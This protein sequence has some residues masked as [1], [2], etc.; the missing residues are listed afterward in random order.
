MKAFAEKYQKS[1]AQICLRW[2]LQMGYLP[3]AKSV[4]ASRIEENTHLFDF[5]LSD[6][7]V[8]AIAAMTD[9]CGPTQDPDSTPF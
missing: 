4:T 2:S 8:A 7:D 1:V 5:S 6:E 9:C 3:L